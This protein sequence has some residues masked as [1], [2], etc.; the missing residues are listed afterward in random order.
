[1]SEI[2]SNSVSVFCGQRL[3]GIHTLKRYEHNNLKWCGGWFLKGSLKLWALAFN[4]RL[5]LKQQLLNSS[6]HRR[7]QTSA[8][9]SFVTFNPH[10]ND[11]WTKK[12]NCFS[13]DLCQKENL[14]CA[15]VQL[16]CLHFPELTF[17]VYHFYSNAVQLAGLDGIFPGRKALE[18]CLSLFVFVWFQT[19]DSSFQGDVCWHS[20]LN[21]SSC[22]TWHFVSVQSMPLKEGHTLQFSEFKKTG[23]VSPG[24]KLKF[25]LKTTWYLEN[26]IDWS[27]E[28]I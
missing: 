25:D 3:N 26:C 15:T 14:R 28:D 24:K 1:M 8:V 27:G 6:C 23:P 4:P 12:T 18:K 11:L 17:H 10:R 19:W 16:C 5:K 20:V 7:T 9:I 2:E 22:V 21:Y 13:P